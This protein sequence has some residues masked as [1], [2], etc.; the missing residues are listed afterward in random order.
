MYHIQILANLAENFQIVLGMIFPMGVKMEVCWFAFNGMVTM[1]FCNLLRCC[2]TQ[3]GGIF[4]CC[5]KG[6]QTN[7]RAVSIVDN[8]ATIFCNYLFQNGFSLHPGG[9]LVPP[10]CYSLYAKG[11]AVI[12]VEFL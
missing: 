4:F 11:F 8:Q 6:R 7:N 10:N 2:G 1:L 9:L 5:E 3:Y 12:H